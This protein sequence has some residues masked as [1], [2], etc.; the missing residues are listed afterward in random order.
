LFSADPKSLASVIDDY[1]KLDADL[2][3]EWKKEAIKIAE[4]NFSIEY[5][6]PQY[7]N[8]I[9]GLRAKPVK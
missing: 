7:L 2:K 4:Q 5:L 1:V 9:D 8:L 3:L 6:R